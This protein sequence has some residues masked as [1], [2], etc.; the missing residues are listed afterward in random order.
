MPAALGATSML[1][2][3]AAS[4][5]RHRRR[6]RPLGHP[7]APVPRRRPSAGA[8]R[9]ACAAA[10]S[11][12][13]QRAARPCPSRQRAACA[14]ATRT[15]GRTAATPVPPLPPPPPF[16]RRPQPP[17]APTPP[18]PLMPSARATRISAHCARG[19]PP[20]AADTGRVRAALR[21]YSQ[22]ARPSGPGAAFFQQTGPV[23]AGSA[24]Q[25]PRTA[26][27]RPSALRGLVTP[28][29]AVSVPPS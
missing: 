7:V 21:R 25:R 1:H 26:S 10:G 18:L 15:A 2:A 6:A 13:R 24:N 22:R 11:P 19:A 29:V 5:P 20:A 17:G 12:S 28:S 14:V 27:N 9:P 8:A 4:R 23:I 3:R 16:H